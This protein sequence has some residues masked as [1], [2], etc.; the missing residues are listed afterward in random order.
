MTAGNQ[1]KAWDDAKEA[2]KKDPTDKNLQAQEARAKAAL[3][4]S[5]V[6]AGQKPVN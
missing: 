4:Q 2:L 5:L 6:D 1:G 3:N